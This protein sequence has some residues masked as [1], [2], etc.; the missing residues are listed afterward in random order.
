MAGSAGHRGGLAA[1]RAG[2]D[3]QGRGA[4]VAVLP[5]FGREHSSVRVC[6]SSTSSART[7]SRVSRRRQVE[8]EVTTVSTPASLTSSRRRAAIASAVSGMVRGKRPPPP[9][10]R[11]RRGRGR[12]REAVGA[13]AAQA[14]GAPR[15]PP[16]VGPGSR[17]HDRRPPRRAIGPRVGR[18]GGRGHRWC[19]APPGEAAPR[20]ERSHAA[21]YKRR[22][23]S[24][25]PAARGPRRCARGARRAAGRRRTVR[26]RAAG[27]L[28]TARPRDPL[29]CRSLAKAAAT[30]GSPASGSSH[31]GRKATVADPGRCRTGTA[32]RSAAWTS[33]P[34]RSKRSTKPSS[35]G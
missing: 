13:L 29:R 9:S 24:G 19:G 18:R 5:G 33:S 14:D 25:P 2:V 30:R 34:C 20:T 26:R 23:R 4:H 6:R 11:P 21:S 3:N 8:Q 27:S 1:R 22:R 32:P 17:G 7:P 35:R 16:G 28:H 10:N 15:R 12:T 31:P